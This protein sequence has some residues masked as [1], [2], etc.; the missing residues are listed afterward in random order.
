MRLTLIGLVLVGFGM[1]GAYGQGSA[2]A[3]PGKVTIE[4]FSD[5]QCPYCR[6]FAPVIR[7]VQEKG[8]DGVKPDVVFR[9]YPLGFHHDAQLAAQAGQAAA[10]QGK[11]W[12]MHDVMFANQDKIKRDDLIGYAK[13]L[14]LDVDL[15]TKDLDSDEVKK[16]IE[17]DL[18]EG[19]RRRVGGTPTFYVNGE[20]YSGTKSLAELKQLVVGESRR[21]WVLSEITDDM[22]SQGP[23]DAPVTLELFVDLESPVSPPAMAVV[24]QVLAQHGGSVRLQFRNF[25]LSFHENAPVAHAA[26]MAAAKQG[27]FW[28]FA[29]YVLAHQESL[30]EQD[31]IAYAGKLGMDE[32]TF[33]EMVLDRRYSPRV[34]ADLMAGLNRGVRGSPVIFVN[35]KRFDGVPSF[36]TLTESI[37][38]E[39]AKKAETTLAKN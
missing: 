3:P 32:S 20:E 31:L 5:F 15:F 34:D 22:I 24:N 2:P 16:V 8:F 4:V 26:A 29:N 9:N 13:A 19:N 18:E 28:D 1:V 7:E 12:E 33:A 39:L 17:A 37:E 10:R 23:K 6:S 35:Q 14:D 27:H 21:T 30:R 25:P 11:F 38:A 36:A